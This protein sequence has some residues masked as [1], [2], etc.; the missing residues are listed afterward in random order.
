MTNLTNRQKVPDNLTDKEFILLAK[1]I[2]FQ[3]WFCGCNCDDHI[4][5]TDDPECEFINA[6]KWLEYYRKWSKENA[7]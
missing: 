5:H 1:K 6:W 2:V 4:D 3:Y 7:I